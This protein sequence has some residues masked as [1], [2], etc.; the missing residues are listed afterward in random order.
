MLN[1]GP[2]NEFLLAQKAPRKQQQEQNAEA[3]RRTSC[4]CSLLLLLFP[5]LTE[6]TDN[7][8]A[9]TT[10]DWRNFVER[11]GSERDQ[12]PGFAR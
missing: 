7:R 3:G 12:H 9:L 1:D 6:P 5:F 2:V 4:S 11:I 10:R 8:P